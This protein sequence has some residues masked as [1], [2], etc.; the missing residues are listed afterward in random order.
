MGLQPAELLQHATK[1]H[2]LASR[3]RFLRPAPPAPVEV[4]LQKLVYDLVLERTKAMFGPDSS[5]AVVIRR[6][7]EN[8]SMFSETVAETLAWDC[9]LG[10]D[11][12]SAVAQRLS[13]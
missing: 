10:A 7:D 2:P 4:D 3:I 6:G 12:K 13:A 9:S 11:T 1:G 5:F 8:D